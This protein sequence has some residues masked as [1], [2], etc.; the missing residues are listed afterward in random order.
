MAVSTYMKNAVLDA[1]FGVGA[2]MMSLHTA[3][4]GTTGA[5]EVTGGY[6]ARPLPNGKKFVPALSRGGVRPGFC[7]SQGRL[8]GRM[9]RAAMAESPPAPAPGPTRLNL[10]GVDY[11]HSVTRDGGDL[12]LTRFGQPFRDLLQPENWRAQDWF[13]PNRERLPGTSVIYR[14]PTREVNGRRLDL[15]VKWCR[16][17]ED[18]PYDRATF[19]TFAEVEFNGPFEEFSLLMELRERPLRPRVRTLRPLGIFVPAERLALW[20]TG[21]STAKMESHQAKYRDVELDMCRQYILL[22]QWVDGWS[23]VEAMERLEPDPVR[24]ET[25]LEELTLRVRDDLARRGFFVIDH[26]PVHFIVRPARSG[27][28]LR[29][30]ATG[31]TAYVLVDY[32]LL[33]RT[34]EHQREVEA[35]RR[36]GYLRSQRDRFTRAPDAVFPP[37]LQPVQVLGVNYVCGPADSTHGMLWVVGQHPELFDYFLPERWRRT[38]RQCLSGTNET[39]LTRTK[40]AIN[41]VW[42][43]S[44][45]GEQPGAGGGLAGYGYNSPFEEFAMALDLAARGVPTTYPRAIYM[46]GI[47][48][49]RPAGYAPDRRRYETHRHL[50]TPDGRPLLSPEHNYLTVWGYWNGTDERLAVQDQP[51][52]QG[53]NLEQAGRQGLISGVQAGELMDEAQARVREAG[54]EYVELKPTHFLLSLGRDGVLLR[55][56]SGHLAVRLCNFESLRRR[57]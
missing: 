10:L 19:L 7:A 16:V 41:L 44:R 1:F 8:S 9:L 35:A 12:Y 49:D 18:I 33:N 27:G 21:R 39:F 32:E 38:P 22:Y 29:D 13:A 36:S 23:A 3:D 53:L 37:H 54:Y 24:R 57:P 6:Y 55:E 52:C 26:K 14:V 31:R 48:S 30:P 42:K 50:K 40:D 47:E 45:V 28:L 4:P 2:V 25:W 11:E 15:V 34:P 46:C 43:V 20:Q 56:P 5:N 17:G 51:Y